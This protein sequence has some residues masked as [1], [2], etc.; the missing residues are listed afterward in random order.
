MSRSLLH[1]IVLFRLYCARAGI[2]LTWE[3]LFQGFALGHGNSI[4]SLRAANEKK[5][6][7]KK[8]ILTWLKDTQLI[9]FRMSRFEPAGMY[10]MA[11]YLEHVILEGFSKLLKN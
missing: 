3:L 9:F 1:V 11:L 5:A 6:G 4:L 7:K 8:R 10:L 2:I